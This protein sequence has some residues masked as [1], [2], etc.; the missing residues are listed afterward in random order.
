V[1]SE[2]AFP[3]AAYSHM[4]EFLKAAINCGR[5]DDE[6]LVVQWAHLAMNGVIH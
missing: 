3:K 6:V 2:K 1:L 4:K 5:L